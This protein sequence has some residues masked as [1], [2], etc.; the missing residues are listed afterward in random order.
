M[1]NR[2][3]DINERTEVEFLL[4][5]I[6]LCLFTAILGQS[7]VLLVREYRSHRGIIRTTQSRHVNFLRVSELSNMENGAAHA[8]L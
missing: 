4:C 1:P 3:F 6:Y 8:I 5:S 2:E 7:L